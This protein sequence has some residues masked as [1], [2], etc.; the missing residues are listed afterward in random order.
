MKANE[1]KVE[2]FLSQ[3]RIQFIIPIYQRNYDWNI[4]ECKQLLTD[5]LSVASDK[6]NSAHFIGSIVYIHDD[7]FTAS[8]LKELTIIDGQQ[9]LTTIT[10]IYLALLS[11]AKGEGDECLANEIED[12]YII[13]KYSPDDNKL[14][15]KPAERNEKVLKL[16]YRNDSL[17]EIDGYSKLIDNYEYF[18]QI[19]TAENFNQVR[20]GLSRLMFVE[21]SLERGKDDPQRIFESLNSTGLE[22]SQADLIRN[23]VLMGLKPKTQNS[24]Y[25]DYWESIESFAKDEKTN[26]SKV[27]DFIR[28]YL[29]VEYKKIPNK[30]KVYEEFKLRYSNLSE[31]NI[32]DILKELKIYAKHYNRLINP[33]KESDLEIQKQLF[34]IKRLEINVSYPFL[35]KVYEDYAKEVIDKQE[36]IGVLELVQSY[37]WRRFIADVS[38]N[39]LNKIFMTLYDK[40][41]KQNYISSLENVLVRFKLSQRFPSN[42]EV[43]TALKDK[44]VYNVQSKNKL[45]LLERLEHHNNNEPIDIEGNDNITIEHIF[46]QNPDA[47]WKMELDE[48]EYIQIKENYLNSISNLT[49]SGNNGAL[50]NKPFLYKRDLESKGYKASCLWL[51]KHLAKTDKWDKEEL[52]KRF[53]LIYKRFID[54]W[55]MPEAVETAI[56]ET[57]EVNI[58]DA[59]EP[60]FKK[61]DYAV[62]FDEKIEVKEVSRLYV[63][64]LRKLF[65]LHP[66]AFFSSD[67]G[68]KVGLSKKGEN[69]KLRQPVE[70][71]YAYC[72]EANHD[73]IGKFD[74]IKYALSL[75]NYED[76]LSI[77]YLNN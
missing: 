9:R 7:I 26:K 43:R 64:V 60:T 19:I 57:I 48:D 21:V 22:L 59:E 27:S 11:F 13:N 58:F 18:K 75:F 2:D 72:I 23:Y 53:R 28:D 15:L 61:L 8:R 17:D 50:G 36:F 63:D 76:K 29:T 30:G 68:D 42:K 31:D 1:S 33:Q 38:T 45:Y 67:L 74:R 66:D 24:I 70:L 41:D 14:K 54:I 77:K 5:V 40:I 12:T 3:S 4:A 49:L 44:D 46:P 51:N 52:D 20:D 34:Y 65:E 16:L 39:A 10:L 69:K 73:N 6:E 56:V 37:V 55:Q 25:K 47:Q 71:N 32:K 62:F 35:L